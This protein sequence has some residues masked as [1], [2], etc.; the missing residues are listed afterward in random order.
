MKSN[1]VKLILADLSPVE[2]EFQEVFKYFLEGH[3]NEINDFVEESAKLKIK[4]S[5]ITNLIYELEVEVAMQIFVETFN[6]ENK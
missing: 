3:M 1:I 6:K 4:A 5:A 2:N